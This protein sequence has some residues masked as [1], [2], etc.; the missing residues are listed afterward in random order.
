MKKTW[1]KAGAVILSAMLLTAC[2]EKVTNTSEDVDLNDNGSNNEVVA[3]NIEAVEGDE[4]LEIRGVNGT[5]VPVVSG[6]FIPV[7]EEDEATAQSRASDDTAKSREL[8]ALASSEEEAQEI[9]DLYGIEL[10]HFES[11]VASYHTDE[12]PAAVIQRG[13]DN[14]WPLIAVNSTNTLID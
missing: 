8:M 13:I 7:T 9:A 5:I 12:D 6:S 10:V 1:S 3:G 14:G 4:E 11:G 2:E